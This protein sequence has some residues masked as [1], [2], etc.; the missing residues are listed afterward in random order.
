MSCKIFYK[1]II[2]FLII[3]FATFNLFGILAISNITTIIY[4]KK[5]IKK[6]FKKIAHKPPWIK[7][8]NEPPKVIFTVPPKEIIISPPKVQNIRGN[9]SKCGENSSHSRF[10]SKFCPYYQSKLNLDI[11]SVS[12]AQD[13]LINTH[14]SN[15]RISNKTLETHSEKSRTDKLSL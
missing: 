7:I 8:F 9:C 14:N 5:H 2:S 12:I 10:T 3:A 13:A 1:I 11:S 15:K 6:T 4:K